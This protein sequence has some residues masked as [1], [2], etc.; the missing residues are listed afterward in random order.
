MIDEYCTIEVAFDDKGEAY[1]TINALLDEKLVSSCQLIE[2]ESTWLWHQEIEAAKEYLVFFKTKK[3][4]AS[5]IYSIVRKH[6]SYETFE[7]AIMPL[8][9]TSKTYLSWINNEV[10]GR[11]F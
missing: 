9:S 1:K 6:H 11:E 8:T 10:K 7:F 4:L 5:K 3:N 2:S